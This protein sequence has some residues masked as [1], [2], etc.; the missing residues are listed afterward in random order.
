MQL[1]FLGTH[2]DLCAGHIHAHIGAPALHLSFSRRGGEH[3]WKRTFHS[4]NHMPSTYS[5]L[6]ILIVAQR[7][8]Q[9]VTSVFEG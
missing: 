3:F 9:S 7:Q 6:I 5:K 8:P 2:C 1:I 4:L